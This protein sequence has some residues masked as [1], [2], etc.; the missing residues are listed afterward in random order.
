MY[1][2]PMPS[3]SNA[4][5]TIVEMIFTLSLATIA[6]AGTVTLYGYVAIRSGDAATQY[7]VYQQTS[8]LMQAMQDTASN[9]IQCQNV[10]LTSVTA[11]KCTMPAAGTDTDSDGIIDIY[12]PSGVYKT[13]TNYYASGKRIWYFPSTKT[14]SVGTAG[15]F[16]FR[17]VRL[18]DLNPTTDSID[19]KWSMVT[20]STPRIYIPG[21]VTFVQNST[22]LSTW[23]TLAIDTTINPNA[24][25]KGYSGDLALKMP[26]ITLARR[27]YWRAGK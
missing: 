11:L 17:A 18:D 6:I 26:A 7:N 9:A 3:K 2:G 16:W 4:G 20:S 24:Q 25:V 5:M 14:P 21:T 15:N 27:C 22:T 8:D 23:I 1:G 12:K 13:L 19:T 10:T